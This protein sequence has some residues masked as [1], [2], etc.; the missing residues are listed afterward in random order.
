MLQRAGR[1]VLLGL[2]CEGVHVDT[3]S[4]VGV[5][6]IRLH[7]I[8]VFSITLAES[9]VG[10]ELELG[11]L[12]GVDATVQGRAEHSVTGTTDRNVANNGTS[13]VHGVVEKV[14]RHGTAPARSVCTEVLRLSRTVQINSFQDD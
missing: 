2:E 7:L 1:L 3:D 14:V 4:H 11:R 10:I 5:M 6:L 8:E 12:D 9:I 13:R